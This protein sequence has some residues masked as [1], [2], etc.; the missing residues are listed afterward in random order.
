MSDKPGLVKVS[1]IDSPAI[2]KAK[3]KGKRKGDAKEGEKD[4]PVQ[5]R[6]FDTIADEID[7]G[8]F[9][10]IFQHTVLCQTCMP[11]RNP[12]DD[13]L[14]WD[15]ITPNVH[16]QMCA[17]PVMDK[18]GG[19]L[20]PVGL[21]Y[22]PKARMI[23]MYLNEQAIKTQSPVIDVQRSL[24]A[25]VERMKIDSNG[26]N[27]RLVKAQLSRLSSADITLGFV[28]GNATGTIASRIVGQ[29]MDLWDSEYS[30][31]QRTIRL[32]LDY[33]ES[34]REH[35][36][37]LNDT[38][39][40]ALQHS[41]MALD[42]YAWLAHRLRRVPVGKPITVSWQAL[43]GQFG[44]SFVRVNKFREVFRVALHQVLKLYRTARLDLHEARNAP[45][46]VAMGPGE[47]VWR[48][49]PAKG[50]TLYNSPPPV[51]GRLLIPGA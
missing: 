24:T 7:G 18:K 17:R 6:L 30:S 33:W 40:T 39:I 41:S 32:S 1:D 8:G 2:Q 16:L 21:P 5:Q 31:W 23:L 48:E 14:V 20:A 45:Q 11:Y 37:P 4:T 28:H 22:G 47:V 9:N 26:R 12:G 13:V 15:R 10:P 49:E 36:V 43:Q 19:M 27:I 3:R 46:L 29:R 38:H 44:H 50:L 35:A 51:P 34:L 25:F 42:I